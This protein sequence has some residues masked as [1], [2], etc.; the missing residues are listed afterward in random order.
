MLLA[1][2]HSATISFDLV[3]AGVMLLNLVVLSILTFAPKHH[4]RITKKLLS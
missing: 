2:S 3:L 1:L 4:N